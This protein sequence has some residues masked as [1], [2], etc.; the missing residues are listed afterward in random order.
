LFSLGVHYL[1]SPPEFLKIIE[2]IERLDRA[3]TQGA[4][5][6]HLLVLRALRTCATADIAAAAEAGRA[7]SARRGT[8]WIG[9]E[10]YFEE[11]GQPLP[12][13]EGEQQWLL[14]YE[15]VRRNWLRIADTEFRLAEA[16]AS[17]ET[18][19]GPED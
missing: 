14:P 16:V 15:E 13:F 12:T 2:E 17:E 18:G 8:G 5:K 6:A 7:A 4:D 11:I 9:P 10:V 1:A 19:L 3:T